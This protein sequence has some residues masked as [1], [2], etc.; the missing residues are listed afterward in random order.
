MR[1]TAVILPPLAVSLIQVCKFGILHSS[2][3]MFAVR[4]PSRSE[5]V[6]GVASLPNKFE[7]QALALSPQAPK[8]II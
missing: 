5:D 1:S 8:T 3:V 7:F 4:V 2:C 6:E